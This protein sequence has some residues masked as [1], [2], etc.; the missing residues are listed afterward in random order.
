MAICTL[1]GKIKNIF[2]IPRSIALIISLASV[3]LLLIFSLITVIPQ[4]SKEFQEL[5]ISL[6]T[7]ARAL[8][9]ITI[10]N[11]N[12]LS[13]ILY[14]ESGKYNL[15]ENLLQT[16]ISSLPDGVSLANGI[17]DS[18]K[19]IVNLAG[20]VG[21]GIVQFIFVFSI[22]I[23]IS[24]QPESYKEA[25]ILI[26]PSFY[27]RRFRSILLKCGESL[28]NWMTGVLISSSFVAILAGLCLYLLG[29][30]LVFANALLAGM[31]NIIPNVG[32]TI[33][34]IFPMSV[35]LLDTPWKS[36]AV[37]ISY[38]FIQNIESYIITPS[39]M[40][41]QVKLL[42]AFTLTS[43]FIFTVFFGPIGLILSLPLT[44]IFQILIKEVLIHDFLDQRKQFYN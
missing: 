1:V 14:G 36:I 6:P 5:I 37:L 24:V 41:H 17:T 23:M 40:Q 30:K 20:N 16:D 35:A 19:K 25:L 21:I 29:V 2:K 38:V 8:L 43:Q 39:I 22:G 42:P 10:E 33:S 34:T 44:V 3:L 4:F 12:K 9:N 28:S 26:I 11:I 18:F 32:P 27:R 15:K 31:L 13:E 7:A